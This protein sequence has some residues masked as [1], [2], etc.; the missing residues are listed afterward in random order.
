[1]HSRA[2]ARFRVLQLQPASRYW[3]TEEHKRFLEAL[4]KFGHK[5]VKAISNFVGT[6]NSTQVRTHAQKYYLRLVS[7]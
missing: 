6:R 3:T 5:D 1:M 7:C 4:K 2:H